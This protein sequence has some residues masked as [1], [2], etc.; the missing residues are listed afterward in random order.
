MSLDASSAFV[1]EGV[2]TPNWIAKR[3]NNSHWLSETGL[4]MLRSFRG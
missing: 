3:F 4:L 1:G 2:G